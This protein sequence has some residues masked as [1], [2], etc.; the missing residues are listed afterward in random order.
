MPDDIRFIPVRRR[1]V[2]S[3]PGRLTRLTG[4]A[5]LGQRRFLRWRVAPLP[6]DPF[7][8]SLAP[9][10]PAGRFHC[11]AHGPDTAPQRGTPAGAGLRSRR[12]SR[13]SEPP[14]SSGK[15]DL[16]II[17]TRYPQPGKVK[18]RLI[19]AM[20]ADGAARLHRAMAEWTIRRAATF[21]RKT[22]TAVEIHFTGSGLERMREWLGAVWPLR[23]QATGDLGRRMAAAFEDSFRRGYRRV[24]LIGTD[25]PDI[26]GRHLAAA[27]AAL[28]DHHLVI[29]PAADGGYYLI[30][31]RGESVGHRRVL[32]EDIP[33]GTADVLS[34]TLAV[35]RGRGWSHSLLETLA[36]VDLPEQLPLWERV[37]RGPDE[38]E[39]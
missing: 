8:H 19:P 29:G 18:T 36:D 27:L 2:N 4:S 35:A 3:R 16:L 38:G 6:G 32:F 10:G 14:G 34:H 11:V 37:S 33:W 1:R 15:G 22:G 31:L 39:E 25:C 12:S 5:A 9:G 23:K 24:M 20:G 13:R 21:T 7:R 26:A 28:A 30:G 17:F